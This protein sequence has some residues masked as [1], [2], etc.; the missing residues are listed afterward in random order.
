MTEAQSA[1]LSPGSSPTA[2]AQSEDPAPEDDGHIFDQYLSLDHQQRFF[3]GW[4][5]GRY[6]VGRNIKTPSLG[7]VWSNQLACRIA[8]TREAVFVKSDLG[9]K[10][11]DDLAVETGQ[12]GQALSS[13]E[14]TPRGW[15][16]YMRIVFSSWAPPVSEGENG[17]EFEIWSGGVRSVDA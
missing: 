15:K 14:W 3:T 8:L 2:S 4:G 1:I 13:V 5:D 11:E 10:R 7:L 17:I 12:L 16:R 6:S 9:T